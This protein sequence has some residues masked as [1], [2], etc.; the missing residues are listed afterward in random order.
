VLQW[1]FFAVDKAHNKAMSDSGQKKDKDAKENGEK[2]RSSIATH[3][4]H[5]P[6]H[7]NGVSP[8]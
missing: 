6:I 4:S 2:V 3:W 1:A 5:Q 8:F 7:E